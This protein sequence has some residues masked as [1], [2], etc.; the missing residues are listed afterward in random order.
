MVTKS[1]V[2]SFSHLLALVTRHGPS[3]GE[4]A[5]RWV[6][7]P[8]F[9]ALHLLG[10]TSPRAQTTENNSA[11]MRP[12]FTA[13]LFEKCRKARSKALARQQLCKRY[14]EKWRASGEKGV[15]QC[16]H[17]VFRLQLSTGICLLGVWSS[18][19]IKRGS[20]HF[21]LLLCRSAARDRTQKHVLFI[22][23]V[24]H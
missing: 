9:R 17:R 11:K 10:S 13:A 15:V 6:W 8:W 16:P 14:K 23:F 18:T 19:R 20:L 1:S 4:P 12:D 22:H 3:L 24:A 5:C 21:S 2:P 7:I